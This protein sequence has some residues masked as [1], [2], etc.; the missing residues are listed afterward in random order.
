MG[1]SIQHVNES[2]SFQVEQEP[3]MKDYTLYYYIY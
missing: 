2:L 1:R 3:D